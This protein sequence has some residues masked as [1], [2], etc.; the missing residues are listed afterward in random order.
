MTGAPVNAE[1]Y[2]S[3]RSLAFRRGCGYVVA[4]ATIARASEALALQ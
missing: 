2:L 3:E 4:A 1:I